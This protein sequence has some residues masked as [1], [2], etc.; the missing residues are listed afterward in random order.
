MFDL[1]CLCV[2]SILWFLMTVIGRYL[3]VLQGAY[4]LVLLGST[5][6]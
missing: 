5:W 4:S 2:V 6:Q 3:A 1:A